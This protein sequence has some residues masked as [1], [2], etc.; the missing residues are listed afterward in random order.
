[1]VNYVRSCYGDDPEN[2]ICNLMTTRRIMWSLT[3]NAPCPF[4]PG[5]C[6]GGDNAALTIDT[7]NVVLASL[8]VNTKSNLAWRRQSTCAPIIMEPYKVALPSGTGWGYS[9]LTY[10]G[11]NVTLSA[12]GNDTGEP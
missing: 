9:H 10:L 4:K 12:R 1:M 3:Q 7:G 11:N 2:S 6:L 5:Q 8:G